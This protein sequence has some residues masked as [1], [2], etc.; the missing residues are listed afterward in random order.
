MVAAYLLGSEV[1]DYT[2]GLIVGRREAL[3]RVPLDP[4]CRHGDYCIDF[5]AR[6]H[7][8]GLRIHE[9]PFRCEERRA[10][11]TKTAPDLRQFVVLGSPTLAP[12][13]SSG[14]AGEATLRID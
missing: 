1:R 11:Q 6:A 10:G 14:S 9:I 4:G 7:R 2:S 8:V 13:S 12:S 5:L 3:W